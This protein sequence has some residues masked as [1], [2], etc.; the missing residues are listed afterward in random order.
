MPYFESQIFRR[1]KSHEINNYIFESVVGQLDP[2][3]TQDIFFPLKYLL[4]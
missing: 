1:C 2:K 4:D 3:T